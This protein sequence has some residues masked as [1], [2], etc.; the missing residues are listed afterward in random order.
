MSDFEERRK[1][2]I[3]M[4]EK[5]PDRCCIIVKKMEG[6]DIPDIDR[7]KYLVPQTLSMGQFV[8]VIRKRINLPSDKALFIYVG[9]ILP[10]T[11]DTVGNVYNRHV[12]NDGLLYI[13]YS[14]ETTFG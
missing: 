12:S 6:A 2:S 13:T 10:S 8:Y 3:K 4:R 11:S 14:G 7:N 9:N 1:A 5:Y